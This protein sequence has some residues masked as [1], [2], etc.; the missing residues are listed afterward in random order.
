[1]LLTA[2]RR[3]RDREVRLLLGV[4]RHLWAEEALLS[5]SGALD[6]AAAAVLADIAVV[7]GFDQEVPPQAARGE[8]W[9]KATRTYRD[10]SQRTVSSSREASAGMIP[11]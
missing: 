3:W 5:E 11:L 7:K 10:E 8:M 1:M 4:I 9:T 2:W 6:G